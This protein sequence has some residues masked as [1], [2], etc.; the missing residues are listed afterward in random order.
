LKGRLRLL[1]DFL[2]TFLLKF[3]PPVKIPSSYDIIG[4]RA[5]AVA[6]V[7]IPPEQRKHGNLI[8]QRIMERHGN[9]V[10]V[11]RKTSERVGIYR[12]RRYEVLAGSKDTEVLHKEYGYFVKLDPRKVYFSPREATERQRIAKQV[13][14]GETI[15]YMFAGVAPYAWAIL[16]K[17]PQVK[18][19][20]VDINPWAIKYAAENA[21]LNKVEDKIILI[22]GDVKEV[23]QGW[24]GKCDRILMTLPLGAKGYL[25][26]AVKCLKKKGGIIHFYCWGPEDDPFS[27]GLKEAKKFIKRFKVLDKRLVLP[28]KPRVFKVCIDLLVKG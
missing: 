19:I 18:I 14:A 1:A 27:S 8:A 13:K 2:K 28:F 25:G 23:C 4:S 24:Y 7:E 15:M 16:K 5:K 20:A 6:I 26:L 10:T 21:V 17:Q 12:L 9:V 3:K 22:Q 11:L